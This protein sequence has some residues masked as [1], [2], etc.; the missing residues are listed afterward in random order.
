MIQQYIFVLENDTFFFI[1][2]WQKTAF[3]VFRSVGSCVG[4]KTNV[5]FERWVLSLQRTP[6]SFAKE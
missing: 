3:L 2:S 1:E 6:G 4:K 5:L